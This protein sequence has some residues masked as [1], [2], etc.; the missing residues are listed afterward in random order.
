MHK[1]ECVLAPSASRAA[2]CSMFLLRASEHPERNVFYDIGR[3]F[4][5]HK[6][7]EEAPALFI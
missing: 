6:K 1:K 2:A 3:N 7:R 5:C 4:L